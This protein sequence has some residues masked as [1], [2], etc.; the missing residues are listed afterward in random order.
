[1]PCEAFK[2]EGIWKR[3]LVP[4]APGYVVAYEVPPKYGKCFDRYEESHIIN[5]PVLSRNYERR[6]TWRTSTRGGVTSR[7]EVPGTSLQL[8]TVPVVWSRGHAVHVTARIYV[9]VSAPRS[10]AAS[11]RV[12]C[13]I[14]LHPG[15]L[16]PTI[17]GTGPH[18]SRP[19][20][21][22]HSTA[23]SYRITINSCRSQN[24]DWHQQGSSLASSCLNALLSRPRR[25]PVGGFGCVNVT[26]TFTIFPRNYCETTEEERKRKASDVI[27]PLCRLDLS[28]NNAES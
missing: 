14:R 3:L 6:T 23:I 21:S 15:R 1:M 19:C 25:S 13:W 24:D 22:F 9:F 17:E 26:V 28:S 2:V 20:I 16:T 7:V 5:V 8:V 18:V 4:A 12:Q 10:L 27:V 11:G